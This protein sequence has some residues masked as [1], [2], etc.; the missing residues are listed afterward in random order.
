MDADVLPHAISC[1]S[2]VMVA[3]FFTPLPTPPV[4]PTSKPEATNEARAPRW[5]RLRRVLRVATWFGGA[6]AIVLVVVV[7]DGWTAF[8]HRA[9][10]PRRERMTKS[11]QWKGS[12]FANP[13]A[14]INDEWMMT[15][16]LF[17]IS[18]NAIPKSPI[19]FLT[20][21]PG[22]MR[23]P[24]TTGLRITWLG[25]SSTLVEIDGHRILTDPMWSERA[26]PFTWMG[27]TRWYAPLIALADLPAIDAVVISHD[28]Y[29][30]LDQRTLVAMK[31][32]TT[33]F[34][35]PLGVGANLAYWG[36]PEARIVE[37]DWWERTKIGNLEI[38]A[39]PARHATGRFL[40]DRDA[41]LWAGYALISDKHRVWYSGDTGLF[42]AIE[43]IGARLGPFDVTMIE[44]GQYHGAW[45]DWHLGP[46]QAV[47][48]HRMAKG[49]VLLPVHWGLL[50]LAYHGWT[51]PIERV[52]V[53]AE[54]AGV[55]VVAPRPG[56]LVELDSVP[57]IE[58]WWPALEWE[59][60]EKSPIVS[61]QVK[62]TLPSP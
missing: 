43:E 4:N 17:A 29:D 41:N 7:A 28:H 32:W 55:K 30:H 27:P 52:L 1:T 58:R 59:T 20:V 23:R 11:P 33:T 61:S 46:E 31:D 25:H 45:P 16:G 44:A 40:T 14:I 54:R 60:A 37:L 49:R 10:G 3:C 24:P 6:F 22:V 26:S 13:Q 48:A 56:Q 42:P 18:P 62:V 47:I 5:R 39:T 2:P 38:V 8:G 35:V 19:P 50:Q 12:S 51:E 34:I 21:D 57:P 15:K 53:A 9:D 36:V